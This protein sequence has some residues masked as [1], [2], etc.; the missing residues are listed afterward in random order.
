MKDLNRSINAAVRDLAVFSLCINILML[1]LPLYMLQVYDRVLSSSSLDT[2][3]F[4][5]ILAAG[6]LIIMGLL[7]AL[8]TFYASRLANRIDLSLAKPLLRAGIMRS[9]T[10]GDVSQ[11]RDL[12]LVRSF[13]LNKTAFVIFDLPFAPLFI[14]VLFFIHPWIGWLTA[15]GVVLMLLITLANQRAVGA[16]AR[17]AA[18][19]TMTGM[20]GASVMVRNG[21]SLRA[22]GMLNTVIDQW[23]DDTHKGV[24]ANSQAAR[25][26]SIYGGISKTLRMVIQ[27]AVLGLGAWLV[28][29]QRMTPGMIFASTII[30]GRA[31]QPF[32]QAIASWRTII[33][34][35]AAWKRVQMMAAEGMR[36]APSTDRVA[37]IGH[38]RTEQLGLHVRAKDNSAKIILN[39]INVVIPAGKTVGVIGPSGAGKSTLLRI[40]ARAQENY[41]GSVRV[42]ET[43]LANWDPEFYGKHIGYVEQSVDLLPGTIGQ[44]IARFDPDAADADII[45][46]AKLAMVHHIIEKLDDSYQTVIRPGAQE[47]S[48]GQRQQVAL[49]R[50]FYGDP[51]ILILDEPNAS[52][53]EAGRQAFARAVNSAKNQGVTLLI[54]THG[55]ELL[56]LIDLLLF[57]E[58]GRVTLYDERDVVLRK[59]EEAAAKRAVNAPQNQKSS[60]NLRVVEPS[61]EVAQGQKPAKKSPFADYGAGM[62]PLKNDGS[63]A[64]DA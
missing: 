60:A 10:G 62:K 59:L 8:R 64:K 44:N 41:T 19:N 35:R 40:L 33:D 16:H 11:L 9:D 50:A 55:R 15:V 18:L 56:P 7:E 43:A 45:A 58:N 51:K 32:D 61:N 48:G 54:A 27:M 28:L 3:V 29:N 52:L 37:P 30:S 24:E 38:I 63:D 23:A 2:L 39:N 49:A 31:L 4:I 17:E 47:L 57:M 26:N 13:L 34:A 25:I 12:H 53:D 36:V 6:A 46:A 42:D 14:L 5:S 22:L 21:Q 20:A 1:T